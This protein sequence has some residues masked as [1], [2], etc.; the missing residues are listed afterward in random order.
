[1]A[2]NVALNSE[3]VF[4]HLGHPLPDLNKSW[5]APHK[6]LAKWDQLKQR[7][8]PSIVGASIRAW[9]LKGLCRKLMFPQ[10]ACPESSVASFRLTNTRW[11]GQWHHPW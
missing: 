1:M 11:K 10:L 5:P 8:V 4:R 3:Q 9:G 6:N 2:H 7:T